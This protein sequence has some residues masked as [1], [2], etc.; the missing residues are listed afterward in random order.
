MNI[1]FSLH[2]NG[3]EIIVENGNVFEIG[4]LVAINAF[5]LQ[6]YAPLSWLGTSYRMINQSFT[7]IV[8]AN[9][10]SVLESILASYIHEDSLFPPLFC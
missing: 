8:Y 4:D 7:G 2:T 5:I 10:W 3:C 9:P 1:L 6:V